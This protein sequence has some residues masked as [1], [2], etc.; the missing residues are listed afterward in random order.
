MSE[1]LRKLTSTLEIRDSERPV[2]L[3]TSFAGN[4]LGDAP[5]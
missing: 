3:L 5:S 1:E 2:F 4:P